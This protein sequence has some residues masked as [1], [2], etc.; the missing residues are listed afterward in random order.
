[1]SIKRIEKWSILEL[2]F[3]GEISGNPFTE[4]KITAEFSIDG[5]KVKVYGFYN[6][7]DEYVV[8]FMPDTEGMWGYTVK[9]NVEKIDGNVG[10][11]E[12][13]SAGEKNHGPVRVIDRYHFAYEDGTPYH[14]IGTTCYV[15]NHQS[16]ELMLQTL[17][18]LKSAA[19]NK[20][21]M[22]VF[23]KHYD[24]NNNEPKYYPF[25]KDDE[26]NW[27][28]TR[29][30][31]KYFAHLEARIVELME[32]GIEADLIVFHP[33]DRWGFSTM[34]KDADDRYLRYLTARLSAF[35]NL[36]WSLANEYDFMKEKTL[37]DWD[38][39]FTIIQQ[40]DPYH[41]LRSIHNAYG[42]Y[43]HSKHWVTH[44]SIQNSDLEKV[45]QWLDTYKKPVVVDE[46]CYEGNI[47]NNWGN[48]SAKK[49]VHRMWEAYG[50]GGYAGHGETYLNKEEVLWWSKGGKLHGQ[51]PERIEFLVKII[52]EAPGYL[53]TKF[54]GY[55]AQP[56]IG[57]K[58]KYFLCYMG[59]RQS[60]TKKFELPEGKKYRAEIIDTWNM[61]VTPVEGVYEGTCFIPLIGGQYNAVRLYIVE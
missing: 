45:G 6:G 20:M 1:M 36:W 47:S 40:H 61:T 26:G 27:D 43:D 14:P 52:N 8:R 54:L 49:L 35:R 7:D 10:S 16:E 23:P 51:S 44:C 31:P 60:V 28:F 21:R 32:L 2:K 29:F 58:D 37:A 22:C 11:F 55:D 4:A 34:P 39:F 5:R 18:T 38:R 46:C 19:F 3:N 59:H 57:Y 33:Y 25:E 48:I 30:E 42:F 53:E 41:H 50:R 12:C 56:T 15:W 24:F 9:S 13:V 17:D